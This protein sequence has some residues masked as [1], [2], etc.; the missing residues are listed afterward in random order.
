M[1]GLQG[2]E[3]L[4]IVFVLLFVFL[5]DTKCFFRGL[6]ASLS[7]SG[8]IFMILTNLNMMLLRIETQEKTHLQK[9]LRRS[10]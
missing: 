7:T 6:E 3:L 9:T 8:K 10:S 4:V 1:M 5:V 2:S